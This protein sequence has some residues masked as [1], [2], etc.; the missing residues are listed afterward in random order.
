MREAGEGSGDGLE[1]SAGRV[2]DVER[3]HPRASISPAVRRTVRPSGVVSTTFPSASVSPTVKAVPSRLVTVEP[4]G[5]VS[6][7]R[8]GW[9]VTVT[10]TSGTACD[11]GVSVTGVGDFAPKAP[12]SPGADSPGDAGTG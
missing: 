3:L 12:T 6:V 4:G 9:G 11:A 1:G 7:E 10:E 8:T 5:R 2:C